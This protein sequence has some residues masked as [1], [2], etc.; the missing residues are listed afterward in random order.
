MTVTVEK[1]PQKTLL[2]FKTPRELGIERIAAYYR[3][4]SFGIC[5]Y[6]LGIKLMWEKTYEYCFAEACG[7]LIGRDRYG[8]EIYFDYPVAG[9]DGDVEGAI[10]AIEEYCLETDTPLRFATLQR[11]LLGELC[12]RYDRA[13]VLQGYLTRDYLYDVG[14]ISSF[15]GKK[16][17]GQRNHI[18]RFYRN[19]PN[20]TFQ[21]LTSSDRAALERFA[22]RFDRSF[23]KSGEEAQIERKAAF[24]ML[25]HTDSGLFRAGCLVVDGEIVGVAMGEVCGDVLVEHI[26]KAL[27]GEYEGVYPALFQAFVRHFG[28]DCRLVNREDDAADRG[29]RTSKMQ[30]QP[31]Q[32]LAKYDL[33]AKNLLESLDDI[34]TLNTERL[35][36]DG[37]RS[38]DAPIYAELCRDDA[39]N[40]YWGYDYRVD[41]HG[42]A[43]D[44]VWFCRIAWED[45]EEKRVLNFAIR[46]GGVMIGE[47]VLYRFDCRGGAELGVRI[48]P[49]YAGN[50]YGREA[51][52]AVA[53]WALYQ[54]G[55]ICLRAKCFRENLP[56]QKML[57]ALM[58]QC[59]EDERMLYF[60]KRI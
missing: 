41:T 22:D 35:T 24:E 27:A 53:D 48:S 52:A 38:D 21:E 6:S 47:A 26:E 54:L 16:F 51:F 49:Q 23:H 8:G 33:H 28:G 5:E 59:G 9:K 3:N 29:L 15:T 58:R 12:A 57:T 7:C 55:V 36:L 19:H 1:I 20:A 2:Q 10:R 34:P 4:C 31:C 40:R 45:F 25:R 32:L 30:Y 60:E 43:V 18:R 17:A 42:E 39:R 14:E 13:E 46:L 56:S 50:G 44:D 37:I 11:Q